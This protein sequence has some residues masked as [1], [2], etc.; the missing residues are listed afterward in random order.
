MLISEDQLAKALDQTADAM[1]LVCQHV[2]DPVIQEAIRRKL[3]LAI[4]T[5]V[6]DSL[7]PPAKPRQ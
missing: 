6:P 3:L 7:N 5:L 4:V 1:T 2:K